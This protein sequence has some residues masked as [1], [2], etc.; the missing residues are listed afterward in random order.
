MPLEP[1]PV[2]GA[3]VA[4]HLH[5]DVAVRAIIARHHFVRRRNGSLRHNHNRAVLYDLEPSVWSATS[6]AN[7]VR[8]ANADGCGLRRR[9]GHFCSLPDTVRQLFPGIHDSRVDLM[10]IRWLVLVRFRANFVR[11]LSEAEPLT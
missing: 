6:G 10:R 8:R 7:P 11:A 1:L 4:G 3:F 9:A 5:G 2:G